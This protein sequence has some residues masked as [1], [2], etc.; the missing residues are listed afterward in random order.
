[1]KPKVVVTVVFFV[2]CVAVL[3]VMLSQGCGTPRAD[4]TFSAP[5]DRP[6]PPMVMP[7]EE[8]RTRIVIPVPVPTSGVG[9]WHGETT[10]YVIKKGENLSTI[11]K[12]LGVSVRAIID[13]NKIADADKIYAG[14]KL[15]LPGKVDLNR[16]APAP[17]VKKPIAR[18]TPG[19]NDYIV[20]K[21][22]SLSKI[23]VTFET[24]VRALRDAN[25]LTSD[26]ILI[27]QVLAI[28]HEGSN[29]APTVRSVRVPTPKPPVAPVPTRT[30]VK[31]PRGAAAPSKVA[32]L[33]VTAPKAAVDVPSTVVKKADSEAAEG[34]FVIHIVEE[35][36]DV[37]SI[38]MNYP[39]L[40][41][42]LKRLNKLTSNELEVGQKLKIPRPGR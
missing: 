38:A 34:D 22:D 29:P 36:E 35:D 7:R 17:A 12:R 31:A 30:I 8:P 6:M 27:G 42:E 13:L 14:Q 1:M 33:R 9:A 39:V 4:T 19:R 40:P 16:K 3:C 25:K 5:A 41:E 32:P 15:R 11:A 18:R 10:T 21:G 28:P 37:Y 23:A 24:T 26:R 20:R 2:H